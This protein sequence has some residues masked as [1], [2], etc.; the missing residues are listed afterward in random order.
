MHFGV[1]WM[2]NKLLTHQVR[3]IIH[4]VVIRFLFCNTFAIDILVRA[5]E[6]RN[7]RSLRDSLSIPQSQDQIMHRFQ[8]YCE[9]TPLG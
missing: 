3:Q 1:P 6:M 2:L 5:D 9:P 4:I 7:R 8:V